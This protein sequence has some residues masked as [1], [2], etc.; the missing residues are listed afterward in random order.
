MMATYTQW[1]KWILINDIKVLYLYFN[2]ILPFNKPRTK[3]IH[4]IGPHNIDM[5]SVLICGMLGDWW[6]DKLNNQYG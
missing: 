5:L 2:N 3:A 4:R 1:P 6:G